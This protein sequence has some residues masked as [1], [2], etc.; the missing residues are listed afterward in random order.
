MKNGGKVGP[1]KE[2]LRSFQISGD[3]V[4]RSTR[5]AERGVD[6]LGL[7]AEGVEAVDAEIVLVGL[8]G[9]GVGGGSQARDGAGRRVGVGRRVE[10]RGLAHGDHGDSVGAVDSLDGPDLELVDAVLVCGRVHRIVQCLCASL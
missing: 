7:E 9:D 1:R 2:A 5:G 6:G 4:A 8:Y 3:L 10:E